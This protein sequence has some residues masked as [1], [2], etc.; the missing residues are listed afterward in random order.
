MRW[1]FGGPMTTIVVVLA[2]GALILGFGLIYKGLRR[3]SKGRAKRTCSR[4]QQSSPPHARFCA[5]CG[6]HLA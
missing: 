4:C 3:S 2:V 1:L 5:H 6:Q